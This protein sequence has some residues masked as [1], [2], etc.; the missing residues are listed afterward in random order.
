MDSLLFKLR[1]FLSLHR[2]FKEIEQR[3]TV[4]VHA[5]RIIIIV[6]VHAIQCVI[7]LLVDVVFVSFSLLLL[8]RRR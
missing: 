8:V 6:S 5:Y 1:F 3:D 4:S 2:V 7:H